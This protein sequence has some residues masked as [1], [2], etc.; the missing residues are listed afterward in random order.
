MAE[1]NEHAL[2]AALNENPDWSFLVTCCAITAEGPMIAF[3]KRATMPM[4]DVDRAQEG[5][6]AIQE[7]KMKAFLAGVAVSQLPHALWE[8]GWARIGSDAAQEIIR[9]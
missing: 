8:A 1:E 2:L 6:S 9:A 7:L 4:N 5:H 3:A